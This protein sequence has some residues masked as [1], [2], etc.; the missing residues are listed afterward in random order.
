MMDI[1]QERMGALEE[2]QRLNEESAADAA[3]ES[4]TIIAEIGILERERD[5]IT[6]RLKRKSHQILTQF[7]LQDLEDTHIA[8]INLY[9][10]LNSRIEDWA[11]LLETNE[12]GD[13]VYTNQGVFEY[14]YSPVGEEFSRKTRIMEEVL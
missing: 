3:T 9:S 6:S 1:G 13:T 5:K 8:T 2:Q 10:R 11:D 4:E 7:N 14:C 12:G